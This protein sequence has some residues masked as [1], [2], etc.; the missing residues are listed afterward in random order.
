MQ[1]GFELKKKV[2]KG[3]IPQ[4]IGQLI[5]ANILSQQPVFIVF[6]D[7]DE[8]WGSKRIERLF[9]LVLIYYM[10]LVLLRTHLS[11]MLEVPPTPEAP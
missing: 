9:S 5:V 11:E 3:H 10:L 2:E 7:L 8:V 4:A 6:T 1:A